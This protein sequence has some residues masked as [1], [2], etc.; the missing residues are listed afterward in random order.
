MKCMQNSL[1]LIAT[2]FFEAFLV[3]E[4]DMSSNNQN[5]SSVLNTYK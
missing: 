5:R 2:C 1:S 3:K 4:Y